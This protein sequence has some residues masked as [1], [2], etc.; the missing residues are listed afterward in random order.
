MRKQSLDDPV[1][2]RSP[3]SNTCGVGKGGWALVAHR[4]MGSW[5]VNGLD[6]EG[7]IASFCRCY[8]AE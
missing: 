4:C 7:L 2:V 1:D 5:L 6:W 3:V 8:M